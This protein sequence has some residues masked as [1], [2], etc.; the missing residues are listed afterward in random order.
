MSSG[1]GLLAFSPEDVTELLTSQIN[2]YTA[3]TSNSSTLLLSLAKSLTRVFSNTHRPE[4]SSQISILLTHLANCLLPPLSLPKMEIF[5]PEIMHQSIVSPFRDVATANPE[6][7]FEYFNFVA[8][9]MSRYSATWTDNNIQ[10]WMLC[11]LTSLGMPEG[12][13][14]FQGS[15]DFLVHT[16]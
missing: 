4:I 6:L 14:S 9:T 10:R 8:Q 16:D 5:T 11:I 3:M 12:G 1:G 15:I 7:M 2:Q 13:M